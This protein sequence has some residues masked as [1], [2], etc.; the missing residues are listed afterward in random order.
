M[1]AWALALGENRGSLVGLLL[2]GNGQRPMMDR[3]Y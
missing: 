3:A 1:T 2:R